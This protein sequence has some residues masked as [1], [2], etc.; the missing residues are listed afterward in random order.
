MFS[1]LALS[2]TLI[3]FAGLIITPH[4]RGAGLLCKPTEPPVARQVAEFNEDFS[5]GG[6][7]FSPD[8]QRLATNAAFAGLDVHVWDWR[9]PVRLLQTLHKTAAAGEGNAIRFSPDGS[10]LAVGHALDTAANGFGLIRIWSVQTSQVI[11]DVSEP[12]GATGTMTL[13]FLPDGKSFIRTVN[14]L[15]NPGNY[16]V[17][18][19]TD[20]W[21]EDWGFSTLPLVPRSLAISP[22]GQF[23]AVGGQ[24]IGT[25][26]RYT[27][28]PQIAILDLKKR[29]IIRT[30]DN[31][32]PDENQVQT[33]AWSPDGKAIAAGCIVNGSFRG[34]NAIR[35]FEPE[36]GKEIAHQAA[37]TAFISGLAYSPNN[38]YLIEGEVDR[39]FQIWDAKHAVLLQT[40]T[41]DV[42][43]RSMLSI[44]R[45]GRY[46][47]IAVGSHVS[48]WELQ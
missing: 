41:T 4:A 14:H 33:L 45:D 25:P 2:V 46:L 27:F 37:E 9:K 16:V 5:V 30:I 29:E 40:I 6:M 20:S 47:A 12:N 21:A 1:R 3:A 44:S 17:V 7:D 22:D 48:I 34:P 42:H 32:F 43:S 35:I 11:H 31:V 18:H 38:K 23:A 39:H 24:V 8:G 36:T 15:G 13:A 19:N 28:T 26:P 10:L